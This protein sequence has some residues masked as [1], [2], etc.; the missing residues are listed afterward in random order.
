M[1][2]SHTTAQRHMAWL[3][4]VGIF[5]PARYRPS[6]LGSLQHVL[7]TPRASR[8]G[9]WLWGMCA[10]GIHWGVYVLASTIAW[11]RGEDGR[12][13]STMHRECSS[14]RCS[15]VGLAVLTVSWGPDANRMCGCYRSACVEVAQGMSLAS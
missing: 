8:E 5:P 9:A 2:Y 3:V 6:L 1:V 12:V 13:Y 15:F 4:C 7:Q 11:V 14:T 10:C